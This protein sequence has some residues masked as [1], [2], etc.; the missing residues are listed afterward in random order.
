L[1][2]RRPGGFDRIAWNSIRACS[3]QHGDGKKVS[4]LTLVDG[5]TVTVRVGDMA[6]GWGGRISQ[7]FHQMIERYGSRASL[8][9][10]LYSIPEFFAI[11]HVDYCIFPNLEPHPPLAIIRTQLET[12]RDRPEV[13]DMLLV[14]DDKDGDPVCTG[15]IVRTRSPQSEFTAFATSLGA[16]GVLEAS[17]NERRQIRDLDEDEKVW[18]IIWD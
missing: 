1:L 17:E 5:T 7:L 3:T 10:R 11:A 13:T 15:A 9:S 2:L 6:T 16:S 18:H 4:D 12:L 14:T 8:G